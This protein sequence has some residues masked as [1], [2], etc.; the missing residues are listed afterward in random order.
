MTNRPG[1]P[2]G[3]LWGFLIITVFIYAFVGIGIYFIWQIP[4][5]HSFIEWL[6]LIGSSFGYLLAGV[7]CLIPTL[8]IALY[9]IIRDRNFLG[10]LRNHWPVFVAVLYMIFNPILG[11]LDDL[12][13]DIIGASLEIY[14]IIHRRKLAQNYIGDSTNNE[15]RIE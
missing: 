2:L 9:F 3:T 4:M 14:F 11:P 1:I 8:L 15:R 6:R 10:T 5:P 13:V 12:V 7:V